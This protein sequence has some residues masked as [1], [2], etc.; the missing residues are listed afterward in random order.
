MTSPQIDALNAL[1]R[2]ELAAAETYE[3]AIGRI[4]SAPGAEE[5][6]RV[7]GEHVRAAEVLRNFVVGG[8]GEPATGSGTWGT[9]A[10]AVEGAA[11]VFGNSTAIEALKLGE[12][13]GVSDY[14]E[15]VQ[16]PNL[17]PECRSLVTTLLLP[18]TRSHVATLER[19]LSMQA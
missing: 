14:R 8:G 18:Q 6:Y 9:F 7:R 2:G 16:N 4:S 5:L 12:E 11:A 13:Q 17:P 3:Q 15:A 10:A 19:L 1:L